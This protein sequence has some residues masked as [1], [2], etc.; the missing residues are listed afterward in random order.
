VKVLVITNLYPPH[1]YGGYELSCQDVVRRWRAKGHAV[2]VLTTTTRRNDNVEAD[3]DAE[4]GVHRELEWYWAEHQLLRPSPRE[5]LAIERRNRD[6]LSRR[7]ADTKPD[8]VS[9]WA[10]GGM[11]MSLISLCV[12]RQQSMAAVIEDDWLTYAPNIDPWTAA[13]SRRPAWFAPIG[14]ALSG[15][16]TRPPTLPASVPVAFASEYLRGRAQH[17]GTV[18]F[19]T[20]E[21]VPLGIDHADFPPRATDG[22]RW[23]GRLLCVGRIEPRKGFDVVVR[24]LPTLPDTTLRLVGPGDAHLDELHQ[25]A[26]E[27]GVAHRLTAGSVPRNQLADVYAAAD[28]LI[29]PSRWDEP[30]GLVPLEAM[31]QATPVVATR[32]GGSAEFLVDD[33]NCLEVPVDDPGAVTEA[34]GRLAA[35]PRLRERLTRAGLDTARR[36]DVTTF[37]DRLEKLH[38]QAAGA[39]S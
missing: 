25:M 33:E 34:V 1:S 20:S 7:L 29:F 19:T 38:E 17:R 28:V 35:S 5:R 11:S 10:M 13:W 24:A 36:Y 16:P 14:A 4:A 22:R 18:R 30:F 15:I 27:L 26:D 2:D 31:S 12:Q 8:I 23:Q 9:L 32:R 39:P 3:A 37:A 6:R 21:V